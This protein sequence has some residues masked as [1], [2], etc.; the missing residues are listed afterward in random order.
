MAL[1]IMTILKMTVILRKSICVF[2]REYDEA[3]LGE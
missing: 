1:T 2:V 3:K